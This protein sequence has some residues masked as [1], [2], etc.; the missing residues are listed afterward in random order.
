MRRSKIARPLSSGSRSLKPR[1]VDSVHVGLER[2]PLSESSTTEKRAQ[3]RS[4]ARSEYTRIDRQRPA[5]EVKG[6]MQLWVPGLRAADAFLAR[7]SD[8]ALVGFVSNEK[9]RWARSRVVI[10]ST[11]S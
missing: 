8:S 3:Q 1:M 10:K 9:T 11:L 6:K 4:L 5:P 7:I 2:T